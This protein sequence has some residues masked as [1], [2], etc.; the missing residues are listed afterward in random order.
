MYT[1]PYPYTHA[2]PHT[3]IHPPDMLHL[4]TS[5]PPKCRVMVLLCLYKHL[6]E[7]MCLE[8]CGNHSMYRATL[9]S[10]R[11]TPPYT[12]AYVHMYGY[13]IVCCLTANNGPLHTWIYSC[14]CIAQ[15]YVYLSALYVCVGIRHVKMHIAVG[16]IAHCLAVCSA[17]SL[18]FL[19]VSLSQCFVSLVVQ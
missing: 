5:R 4:W 13:M 15:L 7:C 2:P 3:Y 8:W 1:H 6:G 18:V 11:T 19:C 17:A 16:V 9:L 10:L 14:V 12:Y